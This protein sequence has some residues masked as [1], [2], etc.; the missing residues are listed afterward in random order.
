[1]RKSVSKIPKSLIHA[2]AN[3]QEI[4]EKITF[5][6]ENITAARKMRIEAFLQAKGRILTPRELIR[7]SEG[8]DNRHSNFHGTCGPL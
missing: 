5:Y 3:T 1:M 4:K 6:F 2:G 7:T 8:S